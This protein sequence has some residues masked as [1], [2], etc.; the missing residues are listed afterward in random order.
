M[1]KLKIIRTEKNPNYEMDVKYG[2]QCGYSQNGTP[3]QVDIER[4]ALDVEITEA[5]FEAIRK[6]ILKSF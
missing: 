2:N 3:I 5:Q 4:N 1:I 6:E